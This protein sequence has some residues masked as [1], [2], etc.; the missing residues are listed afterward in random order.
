VADCHQE[1]DG[2][3]VLNPGSCGYYGG[4]V[5]IIEVEKRKILSCRILRQ[6]DLEG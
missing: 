6:S 5:G 3:W 2:L 1:P 4:S